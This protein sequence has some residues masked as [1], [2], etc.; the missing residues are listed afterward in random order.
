MIFKIV[1]E[2]RALLDIQDGIDYYESKQSGL[3]EYLIIISK[4]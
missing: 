3:G 4:L 2:P 1:I